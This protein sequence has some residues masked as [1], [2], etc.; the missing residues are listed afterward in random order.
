MPKT[1]M[2]DPRSLNCSNVLIPRISF[3][4]NL[5]IK[6]FDGINSFLKSFFFF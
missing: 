4:T 1:G 5:M 2:I 3:T 6:S